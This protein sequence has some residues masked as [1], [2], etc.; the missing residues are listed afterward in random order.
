MT[1]PT[2]PAA[3]HRL[4]PSARFVHHEDNTCASRPR[5]WTASTDTSP[6]TTVTRS[7]SPTHQ[8]PPMTCGSA[9]YWHTSSHTTCRHGTTSF[10]ETLHPRTPQTGAPSHHQ[11]LATAAAQLID[12]HHRNSAVAATP[13]GGFPSPISL[14]LMGH[15]PMMPRPVWDGATSVGQCK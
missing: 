11:P 3:K 6:S 13:R 8:S 15:H 12:S 7:A 5:P 14:W 10:G 4:K 1:D 2:P 9:P